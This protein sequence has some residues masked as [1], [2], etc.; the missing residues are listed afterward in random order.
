ME[1]GILSYPTAPAPEAIAPTMQPIPTLHSQSGRLYVAP[2]PARTRSNQMGWLDRFLSCFGPWARLILIAAP[3]YGLGTVVYVAIETKPCESILRL[4]EPNYDPATC[5]EPWTL[6][7]GLYFT[8]VSMST[9]GYGDIRASNATSRA[10]T[11]I[12]IIVGVVVV[13]SQIASNF[14][15]VIKSLTTSTLKMIDVIL[16]SHL[17]RDNDDQNEPTGFFLFYMKG[18]AVGLIYFIVFQC[19]VASIITYIDPHISTSDVWWYC[20]VT[21]TTVGYGDV[22]VKSQMGRLLATLH[23]ILSVIWLAAIIGH[24]KSLNDRRAR[25]LRHVEMLKRRLDHSILETM[26]RDGQGVD[27]VEFVVET[28]IHLGA[29][30]GGE[31]LS[32]SHVEPIL[33]QFNAFDVDNDQVLTHKDLE[34]LAEL[35]GALMN[36]GTQAGTT[37]DLIQKAKRSTFVMPSSAAPSASAAKPVAKQWADGTRYEGAW[38]DGQPS[39]KGTTTWADGSTYQGEH[40]AGRPHGQGRCSFAAGG[41]YVGRFS[42]GQRHGHGVLTYAN[43]ERWEGDWSYGRRHGRGATVAADGTR[44]EGE[45]Q[46]GERVSWAR[47]DPQFFGAALRAQSMRAMQA[48][49][50]ACE[51]QERS[52]PTKQATI[53]RMVGGVGNKKV[54]IK[55][56]AGFEE[57]A[58]PAPAAPAP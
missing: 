1:T 41:T 52:Q 32:W 33:T 13:F 34:R 47:R 40:A 45:W 26:D 15:G 49:S 29:E 6:I 46:F 54:R 48:N 51:C 7:D 37:K 22:N 8:T 4:S 53:T 42:E 24:V 27:R 38:Q 56:I 36:D 21:A 9:V 12:W 23:I 17:N 10:F 14:G 30:I 57:G 58:G 20:F 18:T 39:G 3:Y 50:S 28:L 16:G 55:P 11:A 44:D 5:R 43:Q 2:D 19:I 25:Q 35:R 31:A